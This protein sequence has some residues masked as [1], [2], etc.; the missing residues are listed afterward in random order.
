MHLPELHVLLSDED[1][2]LL[3]GRIQT[4]QSSTISISILQITALLIEQFSYACRNMP[5]LCCKVRFRDWH[6]HVGLPGL[7]GANT[8]LQGRSEMRAQ[9]L[10]VCCGKPGHFVLVCLSLDKSL[11][12]LVVVQQLHPLVTGQLVIKRLP[13]AG[14]DHGLHFLHLSLSQELV[15]C[16]FELSIHSLFCGCHSSLE[17]L[18]NF[19][20]I[21]QLSC[22][23][24]GVQIC[25]EM[26]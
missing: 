7:V 3:Q 8:S 13:T 19:A 21:L 26:T 5:V 24:H 9:T 11:V 17:V 16:D 18:S 12:R 22:T 23:Q 14:L 4:S 10:V 20:L 2:A 6:G 1:E 15:S 25:A